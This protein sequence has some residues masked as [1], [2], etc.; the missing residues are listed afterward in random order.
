MLVMKSG[1][2]HLKDGM[3]LPNPDKI[4]TLQET[5]TL[6][7]LDILDADTIKTSGYERKN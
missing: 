3:K 5:E 7:N 1:T 2:R 4:R 6:K